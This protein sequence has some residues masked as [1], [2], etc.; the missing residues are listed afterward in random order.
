M[1]DRQRGGSTRRDGAGYRTARVDR[2]RP[3]LRDASRRRSRTRRL[4]E[5]ELPQKLEQ[6]GGF[7]GKAVAGGGLLLHHRSI[8]LRALIDGID[9]L[10]DFR[11]RR[12]LFAGGFDDRH[13]IGVD[14][15]HLLRD[16]LQGRSRSGDQTNAVFHLRPRGVDEALDFL[17]CRCR[18]LRQFALESSNVQAVEEMVDMI[19]AQR[20]YEMNTKVLSAADDMMRN[21]AQAA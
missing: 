10:I 7:P 13:D 15:S 12:G 19:S 14:I 11:K 1:I 6:G 21:L 17:R 18:T 3:R 5:P 8:L 2:C 20:S 16:F 4:I 9:R